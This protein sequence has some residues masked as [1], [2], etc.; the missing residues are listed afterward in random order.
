MKFFLGKVPNAPN[1]PRLLS[2]KNKESELKIDVL[3]LETEAAAEV[4]ESDDKVLDFEPR[5]SLYFDDEDI[6][7][8]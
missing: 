6:L 1:T 7:T 3:T 8:I 4:Q 2:V 5:K